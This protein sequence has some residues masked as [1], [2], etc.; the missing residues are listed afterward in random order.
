MKLFKAMLGGTLRG[1]ISAASTTDAIALATEM[2]GNITMVQ[3]ITD[4]EFVPEPI[5]SKSKEYFSL[6]CKQY[7]EKLG[8]T[9]IQWNVLSKK[10]LYSIYIWISSK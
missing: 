2:Y 10:D 4:G 9:D 5:D 6:Q 7:F 3:E 1:T 8:L